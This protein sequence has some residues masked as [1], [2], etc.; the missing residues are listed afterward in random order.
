MFDQA[1]SDDTRSDERPAFVHP[2][3]DNAVGVALDQAQ[4]S[5]QQRL[6][7]V[8]QGAA[9]LSHLEHGGWF[10]PA[11]WDGAWVL[12]D[13]SLRVASA[14]RG[15]SE[16]LVQVALRRLLLQLFRSDGSIAGRGEARRAARYL[17]GRWQQALVP[18]SADRAVAEILET[19]TFLWQEAFAEARAALV[20]EHGHDGRS[21]L[22]LA[23]P[24][25]ARRRFLSRARERRLVEALLKTPE[26]RDLWEGWCD[27]SDPQDLSEK[28]R[29]RRAAAAWR[30][31][32]PRRARESRA[33]GRCL[34]ALGR[35]SGALEA[36]RGQSHPEARL[37][38]ARAQVALGELNAAQATVRHLSD[39]ALSPEQT[40]ELADVAIR[41]FAARGQRQ[42]IQ[43]WVA[44]SLAETR[45]RLRLKANIVAAGAAWDCEDLAAMDLHLEESRGATEDPEL[46][47]GWHHVCG[48]RSMRVRDGLDAVQHLSTALKLD[49]RRMLPAEA[50][51]LWNDLA[52]SRAMAD[53]LPGAERAARHALRLLQDCEGPTPTTLAL[54][55]LA[56]VQLRRG[57]CQGVERILE[58]SVAENRRAGNLRGLIR[59]LELWV[60]L[61]L[62]QGRAVAALARVTEA[63]LQL[64]REGA[65]GRRGV[66]ETFAARAH[67]WLGRRQQAR[68][69]LER[70]DADSLRELEPEERPAI[71]ALAGRTDRACEEAAGTCWAKLWNALVAGSHPAPEVWENFDA[72]EPFRAARLIFDCELTLPG[73]VPPRRV[74]RAIET[75]ERCGAGALAEKLETRSTGPWRALRDYAKRPVADAAAI[76]NLLAGAGY[77]DVCLTWIHDR[78]EVL[79]SGI[80][81]REELSG[82]LDGSGRLV[83][84]SSHVDGVLRTLFALIRRDFR[85]PSAADR[86]RAASLAGD[87]GIV[88]ESPT[89]RQALERLDRLAKDDLPILILGES[90]TGKE[91][92]AQRAHRMSNRAEGPFLAVN[93]A[94]LSET[95]IE[96]ELFGHVKGSFT[97]A[98]RDRRGVF[99]SA[100]SGTVF[101]DE[102]GD[103]PARAQGKL[104]RVLQ[105]GEISRVGESF[106]RKVDVRV[107]TATHRNLQR[108]VDRGE[109]RQDLFFRL[110]VATIELPPLRDRGRDVLLLADH[111]LA[112]TRFSGR[113]SDPARARL[114]SY[115]WPGN[116]RELKNVL[117]VARTLAEGREI[118]IGDLDLPKATRELKGDYH[119]L[120]ERYRKDL[121]SQA[122]SKEKGNRSAAAARLGLSRQALS[123]LIKKLGLS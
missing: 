88:G 117:D 26:A 78:E 66:F 43:D 60:R 77:G 44:R 92:M 52:V 42:E 64:D 8:L 109:F 32:P 34:Y 47:G 121:I 13:G 25:E 91:L 18:V 49:R 1:Q 7:L 72:L 107:I 105:E 76:N 53:D 30:R 98:D 12:E 61:E 65:V 95:L 86:E 89:L 51:R 115:N 68:A 56:E 119:Q 67:G 36:L 24:G 55:N 11:G 45:G 99:E 93:S 112:R 57:R 113:L 110:R 74:R 41:L 29:W 97:G 19:A 122:L 75:L 96:S 80:G 108:M 73:V 39:A 16:Q 6:G 79:I 20:A 46:A 21:H 23:G 48:L 27:G 59:D 31:D 3:F 100:R 14:R 106:S 4:L 50:G 28:G 87:G 38:R 5:D 102:I 17:L 37:L 54:Y 114:L 33:Y 69:C 118:R 2:A 94:A 83:L 101:L 40:V 15:R 116:V 82:R 123:Y 103:L 85:P 9:L 63:L 70:A 84:R 10:L 71:W 104:L 111:F 62:A 35:Y 120:V 22:W 58:L 90:G 81:G